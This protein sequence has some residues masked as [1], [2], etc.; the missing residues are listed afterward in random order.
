MADSSK[1]RV[2][3]IG[4]DG[5]TWTLLNPLLAQNKLPTLGTL[6]QNGSRAVLR[7]CIQPSSEQAW[8]AFATGKQN[9]KFGLYGF[10]QRAKN[11]YALEY[12]NASQRRAATLWRIL[13]DRQKKCIVVNVP[14]TYPVEPV[15][16]ALVSGLM[17]PGLHSQFTYP[18]E[19]KKELLRELGEYIIDVDIERGESD[20][21]SL[22]DLAE[23]VQRMSELQTRAFEYLLE[24]NPDWDFAMLVHRAPDILCHKF[25]RYQDPTHPLYNAREAQQWGN[26]ISDAFQYLDALNARILE[27]VSDENTTIIVLSDHG[28]GA[29][30]HAVYLNLYFA[31]RGI[32]AY[33]QQ[34]ANPIASALRAGVTRLNNPVVGAVKQ[35]MFEAFPHLKS[36]L[37]YSMAYGNIDW[38]R[39]QAYAI[40]TMGNVYL[41]VRGREPNGIVEMQD[42]EATR[43]RVISAMRELCNPETNQPIFDFVY[44]REEIYN[45]DALDKAPDVVGLIDGPYHI[46]AVD[47]RGADGTKSVVE[48]LGSQLLFVSDTS[49]QHRMDGILIASGAGI[50]PNASDATHR[51]M[52]QSPNLI[53]LAPTILQ[54][55]GEPIPDDMDGRVVS[56]LLADKW[57]V[58]YAAAT[59]FENRMDGEYSEAEEK[60]IEERLAGLGYLG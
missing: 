38:S 54:L 52:T 24:K 17:T 28:F 53:D 59:T 3:V 7:S 10:Y 33:R 39:T 9:G 1:P 44:R 47:W 4:L 55:L 56:G 22:G 30:T 50:V 48:K 37:H 46:A 5:A 15:C 25:W 16:G 51:T 26:V 41:N 31:Q 29:L 42:Y 18:P 8:S 60:E 36:N 58:E 34:Q 32:L 11:S 45:G 6:I 23:R 21:S 20:V 57:T 35:K 27:R 43:D 40:G 19:L 13:S 12:I 14:L 49:G 2:V